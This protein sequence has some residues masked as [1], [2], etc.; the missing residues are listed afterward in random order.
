MNYFKQNRIIIFS[1][2]VILLLIGGYFLFAHSEK[3]IPKKVTTIPVITNPVVP[4]TSQIK[5]STPVP[6]KTMP[7]K[8]ILPP[9]PVGTDQFTVSLTDASTD[10]A[11]NLL[12]GGYITDAGQFTNLLGAK[13]IAPGAYKIS[14]GWTSA[15]LL[16][17]LSG[18]PYMKWVVIPPGLRKEEI[19]ALLASTLGWTKKQTTTWITKDTTTKPEYTEG[20]YFPDTYLIPVVETPAAVATRLISKFNENFTPYLP[21]FTAKDIKWTSA[22]TLASIV[23]REAANA[24][25]MPLVAGILWNRLNQGMELDADSTL[26]YVRGNTGSGWW[27]PITVADKKIDSPFN[28]YEHTGLPPH[29]ISNPGL[30]AINAVLNPTT[31]DCLYY[32]HDRNHVIHCAVTY[33][34]QEANITQYLSN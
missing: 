29:P 8:V 32:L 27:A 13:I 31:T 5:I 17:V 30:D 9:P 18:K 20:V 23:Q 6:T 11:N 16:Q 15:Q 2:V 7:A 28:T 34:E 14:T 26:Q 1:I 19:A 24:T 3:Q 25:D 4:I 33:A 12:S 10:I 21:Q 22:L